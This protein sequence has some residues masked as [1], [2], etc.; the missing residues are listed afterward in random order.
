MVPRGLKRKK[1]IQCH[2]DKSVVDAV[3]MGSQRVAAAR[4]GQ[5]RRK[6]VCGWMWVGGITE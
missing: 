3:E 2:K 5:R 4:D 1:E 6:E